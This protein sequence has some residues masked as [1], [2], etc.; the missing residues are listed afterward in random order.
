MIRQKLKRW[1]SHLFAWWP[2][3]RALSNNYAPS[4]DDIANRNSLQEAAW[5]LTIDG[6]ESYP[7]MLSI[8]IEE[9]SDDFLLETDASINEDATDPNVAIPPGP[10]NEDAFLIAEPLAEDTRDTRPDFIIR[11]SERLFPGNKQDAVQH[12]P[13]FSQAEQNR[14]AF[15]RYMIQHE[16]INEHEQAEP[17]RDEDA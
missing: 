15:L 5:L 10:W 14:L 8:A 6:P 12:E 7:G 1:L 17:A 2:W 16:I 3:K 11:R 9:D 4:S 13:V